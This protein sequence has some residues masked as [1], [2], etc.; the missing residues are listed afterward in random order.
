MS[1]APEYLKG[2]GGFPGLRG[3]D[4]DYGQLH[5]LQGELCILQSDPFSLVGW[6]GICPG[7]CC[8]DRTQNSEGR[9]EE[10][11]HGIIMKLI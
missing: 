8:A 5:Q 3:C 9:H 7:V 6:T 10:Q 11:V 2:T 1:T 4:V